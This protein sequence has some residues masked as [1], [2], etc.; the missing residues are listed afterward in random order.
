MADSSPKKIL[1]TGASGYLAGRIFQ[2]LKNKYSI[3]LGA[4]QPEILQKIP[5]YQGQN[6]ILLD[7]A[8]PETFPSALHGVDGVV[9]LAALNHQD[10]E[11]N[12]EL[13]ELVNVTGAQKL[14]SAAAEMGAS[15]FLYMSTIHVYGTP[16]QGH[17]TESTPAKPTSIYARTH[18][19][20][21]QAVLRSPAAMKGVVFRL[22]NAIG[23]PIHAQVNVWN[24]VTNDLCLQAVRNQRMKLN[25]SGNQER[26][27]VSIAYLASAVGTALEKAAALNPN[28]SLFNMGGSQTISIWQFAQL[29]QQ[30]CQAVLGYTPDLTRP[31]NPQEDQTNHK[32]FIFDCER[33]KALVGEERPSMLLEEIDATL[34]FCTTMKL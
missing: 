34:K 13:A 30:R 28:E 11:K 4:R 32:N 19:Q 14:V 21:E 26:N 24:L 27:F 9:H 8:K 15:R 12:P 6:C 17:L 5:A 16:L 33:L 25:S 3:V 2:E 7:M 23:T 31:T 18:L 20:A 29:I 10:C 1:I 22:A